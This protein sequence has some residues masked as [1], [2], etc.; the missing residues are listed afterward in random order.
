M[1]ALVTIIII[2]FFSLALLY[3]ID[4]S[5]YDRGIIDI[6]DKLHCP[7]LIE[8][9]SLHEK[10][11]YYLISESDLELLDSYDTKIGIIEIWKGHRDYIAILRQ[12]M[13]IYLAQYINARKMDES[14]NENKWNNNVY[15][16]QIDSL[17][18]GIQP[19]AR[20]AFFIN[21]DGGAF[22][23][24]SPLEEYTFDPEYEGILSFVF[25]VNKQELLL[26]QIDYMRDLGFTFE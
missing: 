16:Y 4:T 24:W 11:D 7:A 19:S 8:N 2:L 20:I 6:L 10:N 26:E 22:F 12:D 13:D 17:G 14:Y 25:S 1:K 23:R 21:G 3:I 5:I 18:A 15:T 9:I